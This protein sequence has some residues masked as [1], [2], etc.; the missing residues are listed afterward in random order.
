MTC[1]WCIVRWLQHTLAVLARLVNPQMPSEGAEHQLVI[2][3]QQFRTAWQAD[4]SCV[5][6][7]SARA[8][9]ISRC[10]PQKRASRPA[11][12]QTAA[13]ELVPI[14]LCASLYTLYT[15]AFEKRLVLSFAG[16]GK[17]L[18][19]TDIMMTRTAI[20]ALLGCLAVT[21][22]RSQPFSFHG[23]FEPRLSE[24][25][26]LLACMHVSPAPS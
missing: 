2:N 4:V 12:P 25:R 17:A 18:R 19:F 24:V 8:G 5:S 21:C 22:V 16:R 3:Q 11:W 20:F 26:L 7:H 14:S 13:C 9:G 1:A 6:D 10:H 15:Q 23:T